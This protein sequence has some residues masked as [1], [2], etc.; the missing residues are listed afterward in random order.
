MLHLRRAGPFSLERADLADAQKPSAVVNK[1]KH[2]QSGGRTQAD[3]A[4]YA[5]MLGRADNNDPA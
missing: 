2:K 1:R 5:K 3:E 4:K